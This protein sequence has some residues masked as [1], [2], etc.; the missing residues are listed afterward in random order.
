MIYYKTSFIRILTILR[1]FLEGGG[2]KYELSLISR[3]SYKMYNMNFYKNKIKKKGY[4]L[5]HKV[6]VSDGWR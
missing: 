2:Y 1:G 6:H 5:L 3:I 4:A